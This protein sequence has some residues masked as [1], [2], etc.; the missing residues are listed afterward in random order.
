MVSPELLEEAIALVTPLNKLREQNGGD[1][2]FVC[3]C[4]P[5]DLILAHDVV[6]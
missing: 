1:F 3:Q 4:Y 5:N 2:S 6:C